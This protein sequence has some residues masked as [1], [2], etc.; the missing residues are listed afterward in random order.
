M[1]VN[2]SKI[3]SAFSPSKEISNPNFFVGR[4]EE[5]KEAVV[6]LGQPGSFLAIHG[7]R[8]VGKSSIAKQIIRIAEGDFSLVKILK[9]DR[10][11]KASGFNYLT[12]YCSCD[13]H[14]TDVKDLVKRI[15]LGDNDSDGLLAFTKLGNKKIESIKQTLKGGA[16]ANLL[17]LKI[18]GGADEVISYQTVL[19]DDLIQQFK[20]ILGSVQKDNQNRSGLLIVL[21]EFDVLKN[22]VGFGSLVKTC[23]NDFVTFAICGIANTITELIEDHTSIT[24]QIQLIKVNKMPQ[25]EMYGILKRAEHEVSNDIYFEEAAAHEI[26]GSAEGFPYFVHLLGKEAF[27]KAF[28]VGQERIS[29]ADI[30]EIKKGIAKGKLATTYEEIYHSAV[31]ESPHRELLLKLFADESTDEIYSEPIYSSAKEFGL[32]N[33]S[34]LMKELTY[35]QNNSIGVLTKIRGQYY[36]FNDPVFKVYAKLR[37]WK[38]EK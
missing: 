23:S 19:S 6:A 36:R 7:L 13:E 16:S 15:M 18:E 28:D 11:I 25:E 30:Y 31:K 2:I 37:N 5:I 33:P 21:D 14:T 27:L 32:S 26:T 12:L 22:K 10:Y 35:P 38:F 1:A 29:V 8:G 24:R 20:Q 3:Q 17:G 4:R 9:I 34:Q